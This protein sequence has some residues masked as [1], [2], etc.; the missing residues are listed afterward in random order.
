[1]Q[2]VLACR[3]CR[4][5][6]RATPVSSLFLS[7][8]LSLLVSLSLSL[9]LSLSRISFATLSNTI[10][11]GQGHLADVALEAPATAERWDGN[12]EH[13]PRQQEQGR[14]RK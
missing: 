3:W 6:F 2:V 14:T 13:T 10:L 11:T 8:S 1:V 7:L 12:T 9:S 5:Q 4:L